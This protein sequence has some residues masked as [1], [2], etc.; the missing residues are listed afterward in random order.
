LTIYEILG[1]NDIYTHKNV[2]QVQEQ[3][4]MLKVAELESPLR[5]KGVP[6]TLLYTFHAP[7]YIYLMPVQRND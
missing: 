3:L 1:A 6:P 7:D 2:A 4:H 5:E